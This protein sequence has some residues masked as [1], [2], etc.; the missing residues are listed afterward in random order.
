MTEQSAPSIK[1]L[2]P[3]EVARLLHAG[4]LLLIARAKS[5]GSATCF[6]RRT[7]DAP[8]SGKACRRGVVHAANLNPPMIRRRRTRAE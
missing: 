2:D 5:A 1:T 3:A 8:M 4:K 7:T 6:S